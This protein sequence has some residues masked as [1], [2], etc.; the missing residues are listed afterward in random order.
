MNSDAKNLVI[1][2]EMEQIMDQKRIFQKI[3]KVIMM[4][5][6]TQLI[7]ILE[8]MILIM[9]LVAHMMTHKEV[10]VAMMTHTEVM[11]ATVMVVMDNL[12]RT[13]K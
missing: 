6:I 10:M 9:I 1:V 4:I 8:L 5:H 12:Q 3:H 13:V 2:V 11:V 7:H